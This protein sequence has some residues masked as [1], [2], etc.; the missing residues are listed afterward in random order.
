M[1]E[2]VTADD[3]FGK[4]NQDNLSPT[5]RAI[6]MNIM[7]KKKSIRL[8]G[9]IV[10]STMMLAII[11]PEKAEQARRFLDMPEVTQTQGDGQRSRPVMHTFFEPSDGHPDGDELLK[12][13]EYEWNRIGFDTK[14]LTMEDAK[15]HPLYKKMKKVVG[16]VFKE[17]Y[18]AFC[19]YRWLAMAEQKEGGTFAVVII[20]LH[21]VFLL[22][23]DLMITQ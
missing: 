11:L 21:S 9:I 2:L 17:T 22:P 5:K 6:K 1:A 20:S 10:L 16:P 18:N 8:I 7:L 3:D 12:V 19:F 4:T 14:V 23:S 15:R 13:W